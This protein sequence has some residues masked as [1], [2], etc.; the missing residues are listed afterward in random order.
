MIKIRGFH[1]NPIPDISIGFLDMEIPETILLTESPERHMKTMPIE[2]H[3]LKKPCASPEE[4]L[5]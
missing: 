2:I 1:T 5:F 3:E 4:M